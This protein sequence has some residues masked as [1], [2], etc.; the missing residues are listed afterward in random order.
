MNMSEEYKRLQDALARATTSA[1][2]QIASK[3]MAD[4]LAKHGNGASLASSGLN[5]SYPTSASL[6]SLPDRINNDPEFAK[7]MDRVVNRK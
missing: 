7:L 5:K 4:Y 1:G 2:R 6:K 3:A